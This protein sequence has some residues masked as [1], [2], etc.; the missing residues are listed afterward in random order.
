MTMFKKIFF[1][2]ASLLCS[3]SISVVVNYNESGCLI[4]AVERYFSR[5][6]RCYGQGCIVT[7]LKETQLTSIREYILSV[8]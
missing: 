6:K 8:A 2:V 3:L 5:S 4:G 7:K 1:C